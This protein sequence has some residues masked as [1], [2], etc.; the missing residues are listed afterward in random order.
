MARRWVRPQDI[1]TRNGE[2]MALIRWASNRYH[3]DKSKDALVSNATGQVVPFHPNVLKGETNQAPEITVFDDPNHVSPKGAKKLARQAERE[4]AKAAK[5]AE[6][7]AVKAAKQA[8]K[9]KKVATEAPKIEPTRREIEEVIE[10]GT[11]ASLPTGLE[12]IV[13]PNSGVVDSLAEIDDVLEIGDED[14]DEDDDALD[15]GDEDDDDEIL[16]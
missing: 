1:F 6:R 5:A 16:E 14:D 15:L 10:T 2:E 7:E 8:K 4:A 12:P 3:Y 9:Q 11:V 13:E